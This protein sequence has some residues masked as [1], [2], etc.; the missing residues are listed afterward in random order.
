MYSKNSAPILTTLLLLILGS[1]LPSA[2][3]NYPLELHPNLA[4]GS[5]ESMY[6]FPDVGDQVNLLNGNLHFS[7]PLGLSYPVAE[8]FRYGLALHYNSNVWRRTDFTDKGRDVV[9]SDPNPF[10]N[11]G[12][13]WELSFGRLLAPITEWNDSTRWIYVAPDGAQR[14]FYDTLHHDVTE[15]DPGETLY[16]RDSSYLRLRKI[17]DTERRLEFPDG[18]Y[19]IFRSSSVGWRIAEHRNSFDKG[20]TIRYY[21]DKWEI[22]DDWGRI[23][24][25]FFR[26]DATG[27][28]GKI[29]DR[30]ELTAFDGQTA[31]YHFTY[32]DLWLDRECADNDPNT[33]NSVKVPFLTRIDRP[34]GTYYRFWVR[35]NAE[36]CHNGGRLGKVK[37]PTLGMVHYTYRNNAF[38]PAGCTSLLKPALQA[39]DGLMARTLLGPG[40][41]NLGAWQLDTLAR[42]MYEGTDCDGKALDLRRHVN[43][44]SGDLERFWFNV[45]THSNAAERSSYGAGS[46]R[47]KSDGA[48]LRYQ[49]IDRDIDRSNAVPLINQWTHHE[50]DRALDPLSI[51]KLFQNPRIQYLRKQFPDD[52]LASGARAWTFTR[53]F[54]FDGLGHYR[55]VHNWDNW[56]LGSYGGK[57]TKARTEYSA[58]SGNY[59][60]AGYSMPGPN[61]PWVLDV[62]T[63]QWR[64]TGDETERVTTE[65]VFNP[66]TGF[67][68]RVRKWK[69]PW[70]RGNHDVLI[71]NTPDAWGNVI[72]KR[73]YGGD[74]QWISADSAGAATT[75][76]AE[77]TK[78][79]TNDHGALS[80]ERW[81]KSQ[82]NPL[83]WFLTDRDI[84]P[85]TGLTS[86]SRDS[87]GIETEFTYDLMSRL[88][89]K[90]PQSGHGANEFLTY[91]SAV[92]DGLD[93]ATV[94]HRWLGEDGTLMKSTKRI[95]DA[96]G[97]AWGEAILRPNGSWVYH[98]ADRNAQGWV[99]SQTW[100][101]VT[102]NQIGWDTRRVKFSDYDPWGRWRLKTWDIVNSVTGLKQ[103]TERREYRGSRWKKETRYFSYAQT[104]GPG[105]QENTRI[106]DRNG[107]LV[108]ADVELFLENKRDL[109]RSYQVVNHYNLGGQV[110]KS[111]TSGQPARLLSEYDGRGFFS[112]SVDLQDDSTV[113]EVVAYDPLGNP[114]RVINEHG[115]L[116]S[117][118]DAAGRLLEVHETQAP[119]RWWT[120]NTYSDTNQTANW[121][122]GKLVSSTRYNRYPNVGAVNSYQTHF[123]GA[124]AQVTTRYSYGNPGGTISRK[125]LEIRDRDQTH[126]TFVQ[127]ETL[128]EVGN[129]VE[130]EYP[131]CSVC[132]EDLNWNIPRRKIFLNRELGKITSVSETKRN[133]QH[134]AWVDGVDYY[135]AGQVKEI[136]FAN[137]IVER[138]GYRSQGPPRRS[139]VEVVDEDD[140]PVYE[141]EF[142]ELIYDSSD[143]LVYANGWLIPKYESDFVQNESP[144]NDTPFNATFHE[145]AC[146]TDPLGRPAYDR[147]TNCEEPIVY[148]A[149]NQVVMVVELDRPYHEQEKLFTSFSTFEGEPLREI[150]FGLN[151]HN[152]DERSGDHVEEITDW[153]PG[154]GQRVGKGHWTRDLGSPYYQREE[155]LFLHS[156][157]APSNER[158]WA[159]KQGSS[160]GNPS[161]EKIDYDQA[162]NG[163]EVLRFKNDLTLC[164]Q[165]PYIP[166]APKGAID[167]G[168]LYATEIWKPN[169]CRW[170]G[171][172]NSR[173]PYD[174]PGNDECAAACLACCERY[175]NSA[176]GD[177]LGG[178]CELWAGVAQIGPNGFL[179]EMYNR[180]LQQFGSETANTFRSHFENTTAAGWKE[181]INPFCGELQDR[182][183]DNAKGQ[184]IKQCLSKFQREASCENSVNIRI[185]PRMFSQLPTKPPIH[186]HPFVG[187]WHY[188]WLQ[189][190]SGGPGWIVNVRG[191]P[192]GQPCKPNTWCAGKKVDWD[193]TQGS[194]DDVWNCYLEPSC[195]RSGVTGQ[196]FTRSIAIVCEANKPNEIEEP[197]DDDDNE[198]ENDPPDSPPGGGGGGSG[199]HRPGAPTT[200]WC[201][202][203]YTN[204]DPV[205]YGQDVFG[206]NMTVK[207]CSL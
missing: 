145:E 26:T 152:G 79:Y 78:L 1:S 173:K 91:T 117:R 9:R 119:S 52:T 66:T 23:Q 195:E 74:T 167:G 96:F 60:E 68:D 57:S 76:G 178:M 37:L 90:F 32:A 81:A 201:E 142:G 99:T 130:L 132:P 128:D 55:Q 18:S 120:R 89:T 187:E 174:K 204:K 139:T 17:S 162:I 77:Y 13:G 163:P 29:V 48:A 6:E 67:L 30:V 113:R 46:Y 101:H 111:T 16:T 112:R 3:T 146:F 198:K 199:G 102:E 203:Y 87:A 127:G 34:D 181:V 168:C 97:R 177:F 7:V 100:D 50:Y 194:V 183:D 61:D 15:S 109:V 115:D 70:N 143:N 4:L 190:K 31:T 148:D 140:Y 8:N 116:T 19:K 197:E 171:D 141:R 58:A 156:F 205:H 155:I 24:S 129:L 39:N 191:T 206:E 135:P 193:V 88:L 59:Q 122:K 63:Q 179:D 133:G 93:G 185:R 144:R 83:P 125:E 103:A 47:S 45:T 137:K 104:R 56:G 86:A 43:L 200:H 84:D 124:Y 65:Y 157:A 151:V 69:D 41:E 49:A 118:Y 11:A 5:Q 186:D 147:T 126:W 28:F 105:I 64:K 184:C 92:G 123:S 42:P 72:Q 175:I 33:N 62:Y 12:L 159:V 75:S 51:E 71:I 85:W 169:L 150:R 106:L 114:A 196:G 2:G 158:G 182:A 98:V 172:L 202:A 54:D 27:S 10:S 134:R 154:P 207:D 53:K 166:C 40:G 22:E 110:I 170:S 121:A 108:Q 20:I 14:L 160:R 35:P 165:N 131:Y 192:V 82:T 107:R 180:I 36:S 189:N 94:E 25:V 153:I 161:L 138:Y 149:N 38:V 136:R 188:Q 95:Q 21:A 44:P 176:Y 73:F 164:E 80:S